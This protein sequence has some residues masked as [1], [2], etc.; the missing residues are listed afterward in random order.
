VRHVA[1]N[2]AAAYLRC[3]VNYAEGGAVQR[4][5]LAI[6]PQLPG[7]LIG[8]ANLQRRERR[9]M[10]GRTRC[11]ECSAAV[12]AEHAA[13]GWAPDF[14][15]TI[16]AYEQDVRVTTETGTVVTCANGHR[17]AYFFQ[18]AAYVILFERA[19]LRLC[20]D[21]PR[22]ALL[23]AYSAMEM[24]LSHVLPRARYD[25]ERDQSPSQVRDQLK[26]VTHLA[27]PARG[28]ALGI[29][30]Y[31]T[32]REAPRL[33]T[34]VTKLR[35]DAIHAGKYPT[36]A[37]AESAVLK[38]E[39]LLLTVRD[40][41]DAQ[42]CVNEH[43]YEIA[44][45]LELRKKFLADNGIERWLATSLPMVLESRVTPRVTASERLNEIR[46]GALHFAID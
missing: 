9:R 33:D 45:Y 37:Q 13:A 28:S 11:G 29:I 40:A 12:S 4:M 31:L 39:D 14:V 18:H 6:L 8:A 30:S 2:G 26:H 20:N 43:S 21:E 24:F 42:S 34:N 17:H 10:R 32:G 23:D 41:L 5:L 46:S 19:L 36:T 27:E 15:P 3:T 44:D 1:L 7:G 16:T 22:D 25:R 35:N 38:I